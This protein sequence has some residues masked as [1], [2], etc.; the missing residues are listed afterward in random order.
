MFA[1]AIDGPAGAGK[2]SVAKALAKKL[3]MHYVDTG[4]MYRTIAWAVLEAGILPEEEEKV[5][6]Y[7]K[8]LNVRISYE[9]DQQKME[10]NDTDVTGLIRTSEIGE[11]ASRVSVLQSVRDLVLI[12][13]HDLS[14][15]YEVIMD[16]RDIGTVVL[17]DA[18]LKIYLTA[19][20]AE[21]GRRRFLEL[22]EKNP[23]AQ[24]LEEIIAS[25]VERDERDMSRAISPLRK[26][27][28]ALL[29]DS[30][31]LSM[32][33]VIESITVLAERAKAEYLS[34]SEE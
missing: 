15:R 6:N 17:P 31:N 18:P 11:M 1:I 4:A 26:A 29:V 20:A 12:L 30:T 9:G 13:E 19:H 5:E 8:S 2:S 21:R 7:L 33:E 34:D 32:D 3:Q 16:G 22:E 25:V 10:V 28:D 14:D 27:D 23:G 24:T